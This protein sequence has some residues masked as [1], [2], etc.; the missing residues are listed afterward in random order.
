M[1]RIV[2]I[3]KDGLKYEADPR[4]VELIAESLEITD[5]KPVCSPGVKNPDPE[6]ETSKGEDPTSS[7]KAEENG[8]GEGP[9]TEQKWQW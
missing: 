3:T 6:L 8:C 1:N 4:H 9:K 7:P 2:R 5:C